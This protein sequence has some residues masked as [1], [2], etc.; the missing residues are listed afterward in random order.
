MTFHKYHQRYLV[1][2]PS[3]HSLRRVMRRVVYDKIKVK[4]SDYLV[5]LVL[6]YFDLL[7][8]CCCRFLP[9]QPITV[10]RFFLKFVEI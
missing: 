2:P 7:Q 3:Q 8:Q 6:I 10:M 1:A 4:N 9:A 5:R